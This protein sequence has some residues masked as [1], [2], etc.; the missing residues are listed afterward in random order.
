MVV[1]FKW[2][3]RD[4]QIVDDPLVRLNEIRCEDVPEKKNNSF[5]ET[6]PV[7]NVIKLFSVGNLDVGIYPKILKVF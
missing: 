5:K 3:K 6:I 7:D 4:S 2:E 1:S